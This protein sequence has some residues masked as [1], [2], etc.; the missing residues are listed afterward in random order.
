MVTDTLAQASRYHTLLPQ[1]DRCI[2]HLKGL[3]PDAPTG[4]TD[5]DR[6][7]LFALVQR[8][9]TTEADTRRFESHD[10][11][12]DLHYLLAGHETMLVT[13][14]ALL[15]PTEPTNHEKDY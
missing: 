8:Y 3:T 9:R 2:A 12:L 10:R 4:R 11:H 6:D 13:S 15:Q 7:R 14:T 5:L 1:W